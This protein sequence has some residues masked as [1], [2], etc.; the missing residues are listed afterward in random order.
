MVTHPVGGNY[1]PLEIRRVTC[2]KVAGR[3]VEWISNMEDIFVLGNT[4]GFMSYIGKATRIGAN[5]YLYRHRA[6]PILA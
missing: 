2:N 6:T 1:P 4:F 5:P 3:P